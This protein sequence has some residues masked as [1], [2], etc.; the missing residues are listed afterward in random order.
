[1]YGGKKK[2]IV[3]YQ[4]QDLDNKARLQYEPKRRT[5]RLLGVADK[6]VYGLVYSWGTKI[7]TVLAKPTRMTGNVHA[8]F[9]H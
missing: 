5:R 2:I 3:V 4:H 1:M 7:A 8:F 6:K 9:S